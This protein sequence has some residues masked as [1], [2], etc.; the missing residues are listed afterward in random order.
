MQS[1]INF[2]GSVT[3]GNIISGQI[4]IEMKW[5]DKHSYTS[6][7]EFAALSAIVR[8]GILQIAKGVDGINADENIKDI[9]ISF[10]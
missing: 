10:R 7:E 2:I 4:R 3:R 8:S 9:N 1:T 5:D 6:S